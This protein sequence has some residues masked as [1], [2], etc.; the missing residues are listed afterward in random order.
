M[1]A[2]T[3]EYADRR[4]TPGRAY[5]ELYALY[6]RALRHNHLSWAARL[7]DM[8]HRAAHGDVVMAGFARVSPARAQFA[9]T[10]SVS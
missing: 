4:P 8:A 10:R 7:H 2:I 5:A 1:D 3:F 9:P 6:W